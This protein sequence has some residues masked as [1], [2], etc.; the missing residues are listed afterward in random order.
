M[1]NPSFKTKK[2]YTDKVND[3]IGV[4]IVEVDSKAVYLDIRKFYRDQGQFKPSKK[5]VFL[6][7]KQFETV[8]KI[9]TANQGDIRRRLK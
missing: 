7:E 1:P 6:N 8:L 5:G 4:S 3:P 9:L 2:E